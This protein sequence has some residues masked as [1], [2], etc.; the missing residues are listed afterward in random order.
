MEQKNAQTPVIIGIDWLQ[1][2]CQRSPEISPKKLLG[3]KLKKLPYQTRHFALVEE[4]YHN[5]K[6]I[7]VLV[8][9]PHSPI[10]P[11]NTVQI[12]M[13]NSWLYR[14]NIFQEFN[15]ILQN[16]HL[17][18]M[19]FSRIDFYCDFQNFK[20]NLNPET[21]IKGFLKNIY[22]KAGRGKFAVQGNN[23]EEINFQYLRFGTGSSP[24]R[25]YLY[26]KSDEMKEVKKKPHIE[27]TW[28]K[29]N[30]DKAKS[31]WRL[32]V[33]INSAAKDAVKMDTGEIYSLKDLQIVHNTIAVDF[34]KLL[35]EKY[36]C[37]YHNS[38]QRVV[39]RNK[40]LH[41]FKWQASKM[42]YISVR[43]NEESNRSDKIF[44]KKLASLNNE[45]RGT[46]FDLSIAAN[47]VYNFFTENRELQVWLAK[48]I[49]LGKIEDS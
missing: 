22:K 39:S 44:L 47:S 25:V 2:S 18:F 35:V 30:F 21:L 13:L 7:A 19:N 9:K 37:W 27:E 16:L 8:S 5:G 23:G 14:N 17:K 33:S 28:E 1:A 12:K 38:G 36:F 48:Q 42:R 46:D 11:P 45:L 15:T 49:S 6:A 31:T 40:R 24:V 41:L 26:N 10:I 32:E 43:K 3:L 20:N 34:F 4:V 29:A